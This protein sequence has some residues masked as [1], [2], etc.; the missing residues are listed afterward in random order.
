MEKFTLDK[1]GLAATLGYAKATVDRKVSDEP[2][3]LPPFINLGS[4]ARM[5]PVWLMD[6]VKQWLK[7]REGV[8]AVSPNPQDSAS[9]PT[10]VMPNPVVA[11][12]GRG[13]PKKL[14]EVARQRGRTTAGNQLLSAARR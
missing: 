11:K 6:T 14:E 8:G 2:E 7:D 13:R 3:T 9:S 5:K 4:A 12:R 1:E 10:R